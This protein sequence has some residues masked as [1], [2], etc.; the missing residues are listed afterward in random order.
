MLKKRIIACLDIDKGRVVK[1]VCFEGLIDAGD[2]VELCTLY[3]NSCIDELCLLDITATSDNRNSLY[4]TI[5]NVAQK[6]SIPFCVGGG[7]RTLDDAKRIINCGAD[8][9]SIG[10]AAVTNINL[11]KEVSLK[12][13]SQSVVVS[14]D[15]KKHEDGNYYIYKRGGRE[16]CFL[17]PIEFALKCQESGAGEILLNSINKDGNKDGFDLFINNEVSSILKIPVIASGGAGKRE[18]FLDLFK[19]TNVN[20]ALAA[21]IF[22]FK[23]IEIPKLKEYLL[24]N[25]IDIRI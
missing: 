2:P 19:K 11:V 23:D 7:V 6:C 13:G 3:D 9:V 17:N 1:G 21:S 18:D 16:C 8:K 5:E 10:S 15:V 22:H 14:L 20:A 12:F 24:S 25:Y 4:K